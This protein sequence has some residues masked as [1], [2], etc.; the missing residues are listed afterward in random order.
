LPDTLTLGYSGTTVLET[1]HLVVP[2]AM[3]LNDIALETLKNALGSRY[4]VSVVK[5]E[6]IVPDRARNQEEQISITSARL[7]STAKP[8]A[9]DAIVIIVP[10]FSGAGREEAMGAYFVSGFPQASSGRRTR[11][12]V[13]CRVEIFDG[14]TF[15][16]IGWS[17]AI[18]LAERE[19]ELP[20]TRQPYA[21]LSEAAQATIRSLATE[22]ITLSMPRELRGVGLVD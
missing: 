5:L 2:A 15:E 19:T 14:K 9:A 7:K 11:V 18:Q 6:S 20:W 4:D 21:E 17:R 12:G 16:L 22:S 13:I 8:A 1:E 3:G 10:G